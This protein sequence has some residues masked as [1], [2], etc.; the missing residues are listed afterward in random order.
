LSSAYCLHLFDAGPEPLAID[1]T[2]AHEGRGQLVAAQ[3]GDEVGGLPITM[4]RRPI[5]ALAARGGVHSA[6][7]FWSKPKSAAPGSDR[8]AASEKGEQLFYGHALA[9][10]T[11]RHR[12][13]A[14]RLL[15]GV[16]RDH[17][18]GHVARGRS[19]LPR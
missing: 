12:R 7:S 10:F 18:S 11:A 1:R 16:D 6:A 19:P 15:A 2:A 5:P 9:R 4:G 14:R 13:F 8:A 3:P 17:L